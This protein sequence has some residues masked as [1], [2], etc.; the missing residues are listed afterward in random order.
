[1]LLRPLSMS[2]NVLLPARYNLSFY[3]NVAML[4]AR[5]ASQRHGS[6]RHADVT[7][8]ARC[9]LVT[10]RL[11]RAGRTHYGHELVGLQ[12]TRDVLHHHCAFVAAAEA[13]PL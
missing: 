8:S 6:Q 9:Q 7:S 13:L 1:M 3:S 11:A 2:I 10:C 5:N 12:L 4:L